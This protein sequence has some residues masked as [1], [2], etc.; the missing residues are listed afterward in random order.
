LKN[1]KKRVFKSEKRKM[2]IRERCTAVQFPTSV[3]N[4][5][6]LAFAAECR[7]AA[8]LSG[9]QQQT[10]RSD[11]RRPNDGTDRLTHGQTLDISQTMLRSWWRGTVVER[12][13]L[14]GE[15]S[16]SCARPAADG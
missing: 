15:L 10:R 6:L 1:T 9:T 12:R 16:L 14:A 7:A 8:P 5:A 3:V 2:R 13:S 11:A 4:V